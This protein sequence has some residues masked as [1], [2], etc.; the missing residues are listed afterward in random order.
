[1]RLIDCFIDVI[2]YTS[3]FRAHS[4]SEHRSFEDVRDDY[5]ELFDKS[6]EYRCD[7][8]FSHAEWDTAR[9]AVC[10]WIDESVLCSLWEGKAA[11]AHRQLQREY[12]DTTNGGEE[13]F[14][15]L[16]AL[17]PEEKDIREVYAYCLGL[18]FQGRY[19]RKEDERRLLHVKASN[20]QYIM[21]HNLKS[22]L[23]GDRDNLFPG[24]YSVSSGQVS[25]KKAGSAISFFTLFFLVW[26]PALF[27]ALFFIYHDILATYVARF[28]GN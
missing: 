3:Y 27:A 7:E 24:A 10:A 21:E 14:E 13:F 26:P 19:F 5:R 22:D 11:W 8:K 4:E 6:E 12:Y 9:F 28:L 18:G 15:R 17:G 2:T 16:D 1:M 23:A 20:L 25:R